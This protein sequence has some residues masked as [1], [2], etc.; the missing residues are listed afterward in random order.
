MSE[1]QTERFEGGTP[2]E[3]RV[4]R[5]LTNLNNRLSTLEEKVDSRLK[6]TRP[7][8]E[9]VLLRLDSM[10][11]RLNSVD[12]RLEKVEDKFATVAEELLDMR[13]DIGRLKKRLPAA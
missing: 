1:E 6:E 5:E 4:L 11:N 9:A 3:I 12:T 8:W 7:I 10:D 2:F 13:T